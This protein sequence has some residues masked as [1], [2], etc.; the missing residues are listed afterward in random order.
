MD[1]SFSFMQGIMGNTI[2]QPPQLIDSANIRQE[3]VY[4]AISDPGDDGGQQN[5][6]SPLESGFS[7]PAED[8][9]VITNGYPASV[10]SYEQQAKFALYSQFPNGSANGYGA[11][12]NYGDHG[13]LLGE[14]T[15]LRQ[16][17]VQEK[18]QTHISPPPHP[19]HHHQPHHQHHHH[20]QQ[21]HPHNPPLL[22]HHHHPPPASHLI[23]QVLPPPPPLLLPSSPPILLPQ[24][25]TVSNPIAQATTTPKKTSSPEI[26][27][28][29]IKTYQNGRELFESSLCGDLLQEVQ[30]GEASSRRHEQKKEKRKKRSSRHGGFPEQEGLPLCKGAEERS[31]MVQSSAE[32]SE[33]H[34]SAGEEQ[35]SSA[36]INPKAEPKEQRVEK[37]FPS[38]ITST[39]SCKMYEIGDLVWAKVGTYPWWPCMVSSDPQ[40]SVHTRIN[41]RGL[42]EY[43]VQFFGS[44]PERAWVNERRTR[45]YQ[46][47][48]QF[49]ELQ[50]ETLRKT[51]NP[52][53]KQK[54]LKPQSQKERAQWEVGMGHAEAA[55]LMT[56]EERNENYTFIYIDKEPGAADTVTSPRPTGKP[57]PERKQRRSRAGSK[58]KE[59]TVPR[60]QQPRRQC[61]INSLEEPSSPNQGDDDDDDD[62]DDMD[63]KQQ[64]S[65]PPEPD[66]QEPSPP[67]VRT[68]WRTAAARKLLPLSITMKKLNVEIIKC[69]WQL[70]KD[71]LEIPKKVESEER[72]C[73]EVR[74]PEGSSDKAEPETCSSEEERAASP[75]C[76]SDQESAEHASPTEQSSEPLE[77]KQQR[78]S[79][80]SR[81]ESEKSV[82]PVPKKKVKKEQ[83]ET[84]PQMDFKTG[85]QKGASEISDSCK[86]LKKR[87]RASTDVEMASSLYRDTSDS[88]SR[89][90]NDPQTAFGKRSDSPAT[91]DADGSDAQ[92]VDSSL[93][94]QGGS[95]SKKDTVCHVCETFGDSLVS[96]EGECNRLFHPDCLASNNGTEGDLMC[97]ECKTGSHI[98]FSC[99][100]SEG[101]LKR[102]SVNG[103]GRFYHDTCARRHPGTTTDTRG[104]RC[105]QHSC[106]T[107]CLDRDLH[108]ASKGRM[109]RCIRCPIAYH[110]GD[111]C[112]AAG[113]LLITPHIIICSNHSS[114]RRNGH[115]SSPVNVGWCFICARGLL[116]HDHT[117]T[118]LSSYT[119]KSHYLLTES[120]RAELMKLPMIPSSSSATKK[121]IGKGGRLL[122]CE[123]CP[124][125]FHPECLNM[126]MPE[127]TWLCGECRSGKKPH[128]KQIVWVKL[129]NYRWWP[130]EICNPRL[131]PSNIQSLKHDIGDFP[132]FFFGSH[133]YYWINQGR[134]F[135]YVE[136]DKN[137]AE[138]QVG[139]NKTFKKALEEAAKRFQELKAQ[140][141]TKEALEQERNSRRPPPYKL[142]KSNKPVGKVQVHVAD[143]SEIPRCNCK[144]TDE[145]PCSQ[146]S[147]CLNRMLQYECHPQVCPAG[148]RC[149]NQ[150]FSKRLY[151]DS[152]VIK[153]SGRGWGLKTKQDLKKGDF[154]M[155]YVGE[156]IDSEECKQR[157][158]HSNENHVTNFYML[159]LTKDRVI[160]AGPKGNLSRFMNHSCSPNCETQKWTVNGDVRIGLF[161][162]CDIA[163]DTELTFNY[164]LDCLGNGRTSC[165][166]G[167]ENCSGFLGVKPK[168]AVVMEREEKVRNAK[169]KPKKRKLKTESKQT[170][171]YF[172]YCCGEGGELV[173]CD[174]K[175]CP[176]AYHLLCLNLTKP[177][178]GRWECPWHQCSVCQRATSS[179]CHFCP[180]SFC[181]DH[182]RGQLSVSAIDNRPCCS[183]HDPQRPLGP[184]ANLSQFTI[185]NEPLELTEEPGEDGDEEVEGV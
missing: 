82:E 171:E 45:V 110:T 5:F 154:V 119:F 114:S 170:H 68:P 106:A 142:I 101:E 168:S 29:I 90:L 167:A 183:N 56:R 123:A 161:T 172:C 128:Y 42:R 135:P 153:T 26:K 133:D 8:L 89:G 30:A 34:I 80:R 50:A 97:T 131:V 31:G 111:G 109:M 129:G 46:G 141:E 74:S 174:R 115:F 104:L 180:T 108:K 21:H 102:C 132:V 166:C 69:D 35:T 25:S 48:S 138:G 177:P 54:L 1:F 38:V 73:E 112:V 27:I 107:C 43:H 64:P 39:G 137:F 121:N 16:P 58:G 81:S 9:P 14:G 147:Q 116:V 47:E 162:S 134:V 52:T 4:E 12:R 78:R 84:A 70:Q 159:T 18:P 2:Q 62:D 178:S 77:R 79:V 143:L 144:P 182:E 60:R 145:R 33:G 164:N 19:H 152:E 92:S 103:C 40:T 157:I 55:L 124:A 41:T 146:D 57:R 169:L 163:A 113:S 87:S 88:D 28:K 75:A 71:K 22:P 136:S 51:T 96:C 158:R 99:N 63:H 125:S 53:E 148:D 94:R 93:S 127:G 165:H 150:C 156:L 6:E 49:E 36:L 176:K 126:E 91:V 13:L 7:Y 120:N 37:H 140:R 72:P 149:Q 67:P 85:S 117:D 118:V 44:V 130:A 173:M 59:E 122:C 76:W 15:V 160:D 175:D 65:S 10:G 32:H 185:K 95:S 105:P 83:M 17:M 179:F 11:I 184:T 20:H 86:P 181:R 139:I 3:D 155:E 100:E 61:S 23:P 98:C 151:P 24:D 66:P